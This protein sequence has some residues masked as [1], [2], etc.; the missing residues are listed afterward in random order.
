MS[1]C[2]VHPGL[3]AAKANDPESPMGADKKISNK[4]QF[5]L[6]KGQVKGQ[7]MRQKTFKQ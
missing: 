5:S 4:S 3:G 6:A 1:L 7:H 2:F